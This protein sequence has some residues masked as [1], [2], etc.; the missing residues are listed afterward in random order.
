MWNPQGNLELP[1]PLPGKDYFLLELETCGEKMSYAGGP[2]QPDSPGQ[3]IF[4][5][6]LLPRE[7]FRL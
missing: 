6:L 3:E 7:S 1:S 4:L 2:H 5:L